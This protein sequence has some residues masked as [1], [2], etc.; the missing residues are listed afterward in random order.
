MGNLFFRLKNIKLLIIHRV[1]FSS[2]RVAGKWQLAQ[3]VTNAFCVSFSSSQRSWGTL[4]KFA[5]FSV[6]KTPAVLKWYLSMLFTFINLLTFYMKADHREAFSVRNSLV[7]IQVLN[8]YFN[9]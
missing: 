2:F 4:A 8:I 1:P 6:K 5:Y 3:I 7:K 9:V